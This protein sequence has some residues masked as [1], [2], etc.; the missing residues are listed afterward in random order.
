MSKKKTRIKAKAFKLFVGFGLMLLALGIVLILNRGDVYQIITFPIVYTCFKLVLSLM[1]SPKEGGILDKKKTITAVMP[2]YN[3][4][5][6]NVKRGFETLFN[7]DYEINQFIFVDDGSD[8][9]EVYQYVKKL[10][11]VDQRILALRTATNQGKKEA[12]LL[13]FKYVTSE[14]ILLF[15][16]DSLLDKEAVGNLMAVFNDKEVGAAVG[17]IKVSNRNQNFIVKMQK[18][19]YSSAFRFSRAAQS[20]TG[21]VSVC[22]GA[23]S[24]FKFRIIERNLRKFTNDISGIKMSNGDDRLLTSMVLESGYKTR[25]QSN[26][27]CYTEVPDTIPRFLKQQV[28]WAKS[29]FILA[30]YSIKSIRINPFIPIWQYIDAYMWLFNFTLGFYL[31]ASSLY[32]GISKDVSTNL[33]LV[34][35][36]QRIAIY[37]I[38]YYCYYAVT[39][40]Y[41]IKDDLPLYIT[42][43]I[44]K[45]VYSFLL[46]YIRVKA[47]ITIRKDSWGT[48]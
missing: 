41:V 20:L 7:Q 2:N 39:N 11:Q 6:I 24:V 19:L 48:R 17:T 35:D 28:R 14:Y 36:L 9:D 22:S 30:I 38:Y 16:T 45:F 25:Y 31:F 8:S 23:F 5:L 21:C 34:P 32:F 1:Y 12:Q 43:V 33:I 13:A 37:C 42:G 29:G 47:L 26:A 3:E 4:S 27:I 10:S 46:I 44:H 40:F 18:L 15:D